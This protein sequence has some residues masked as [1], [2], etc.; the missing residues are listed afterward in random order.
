M[1]RTALLLALALAPTLTRAQRSDL[2]AEALGS[3]VQHLVVSTRV[4]MIGAHPDDEDTQIIAWLSR[5]R[6]VETAYLSLTRGEG[7]QNI[8][9]G[10]LGDAL[11][12]LRTEELL[13]ARRIDGAQQFFT[14]AFDFGFSK[15]AEETFTQWPRDEMLRQVVTIIRL[16]RPHVIVSVFSGTPRDGHGHHQVAGI[17]AREAYDAAGDSLRVPRAATY[18]LAPWTSLK[19][20]RGT[21]FSPD[22]ATLRINV[23]EFSPLYGRSYAEIAAESRSQHKSQAFGALARR[24]VRWDGLQLEHSRVAQATNGAAGM[25][26]SVFDGIDTT[27]SRFR[28]LLPRSE[29]AALFDSLGTQLHTVQA[30][31]DLVAPDRSIPALSAVTRTLDALRD[32]ALGAFYATRG[33][34]Q[35]TQQQLDLVTAL[36]TARDRTSRAIQLAAGIAVEA[37]VPREV[38][39][40]TERVPVSIAIY[41]RGRDTV[42]VLER[43]WDMGGLQ[44]EVPAGIPSA[45]PLAP[46]SASADSAALSLR[47]VTVPWWM[48][49]GR[50]GAMYESRGVPGPEASRDVAATLVHTFELGRARFRVRTPVVYRYA[51]QVKGE[52]NR[53]LAMAPAVAIRLGRTMEYARAN[54]PLDRTVL[55]TVSSSLGAPQVVKVALKTPSG[56]TTDSMVRQ[57]QLAGAGSTETIPFRVRGRL[58]RGA[59]E[60]SA[61][62]SVG[63]QEYASGYLLVDYDH[64]RP[65]RMYVAPKTRLTSVNVRVPQGVTVAY[66]PGVAD[67]GAAAL[68]QLGVPVTVIE[69]AALRTADLRRFSTLVVGPRAYDASAE[70]RASRDIVLAFARKGGTVVVQYGQY[71]MTQPGIMPYP[72]TLTRPADRVTDETAPVRIA[73]PNATVLRVPNVIDSTDFADWVQERGLYMPR[74]FDSRYSAALEM[75]DPGEPPNRGAVLVAPV[76][77]GLYIYTT[78]SLFRQLPSGVPGAARLFV[79]LVSARRETPR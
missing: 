1:R 40:A 60:L 34:A 46:D 44:R 76:G 56:L 15:T 73:Q 58:S 41:N 3:L 29:H 6:G 19:F 61:V 45:A 21:F 27:W 59:F 8:I 67:H 54:T 4:L 31:V 30:G 11:G 68:E 16:F 36:E 22:G 17:L 63:D 77:R 74:T 37:T 23:G 38:F 64:I 66:V 79:N 65:R 9:G 62:A 2:G 28:A 75:N 26:R 57:V 48:A 43:R 49:G 55:V 10:E 32:V 47:Y 33:E 35:M 14:R 72:I 13:A 69:P 25:E 24:G 18:G 70:L 5:A 53:A 20:Y 39:A 50:T 12:I 7:G 71:E 42:R 52:L 51:D 78:L